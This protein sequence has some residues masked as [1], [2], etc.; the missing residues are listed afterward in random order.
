MATDPSEVAGSTAVALFEGQRIRRE[1]VDDRWHFSV[2]NV[3]VP[4][5]Q[6]LEARLTPPAR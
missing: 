6:W 5:Y 4:L 3:A 1:W 2:V